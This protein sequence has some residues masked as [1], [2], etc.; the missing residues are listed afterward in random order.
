MAGLIW[1]VQIV[2]YPLFR[3]VG[4]IGYAAYQEAH[5]HRTTIVVGVPM[6]LELASALGLFLVP[7]DAAPRAMAFL[8]AGLLAI[9]WLSTATVQVPLHARLAK[10]FDSFAASRLVASNWV[11]TIGWTLRGVIAIGLLAVSPCV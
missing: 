7:A 1:F 2:H 4:P 11:R 9:V 3:R 8:G 6:L 10:G 5:M